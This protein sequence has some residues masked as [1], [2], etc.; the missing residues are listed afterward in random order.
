MSAM[1]SADQQDARLKAAAGAVASAEER[2][3]TAAHLAMEAAGAG[4]SPQGVRVA[5]VTGETKLVARQAT[6]ARPAVA[7]APAATAAI[8]RLVDRLVRA[9]QRRPA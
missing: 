8:L 9:T 4:R 3:P 2:D 7:A 1:A 5:V 6:V